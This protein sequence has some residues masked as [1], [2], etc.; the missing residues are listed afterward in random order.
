MEVPG[1]LEKSPGP[2]VSA[3]GDLRVAGA[4]RDGVVA[5]AAGSITVE[6]LIEC[7]Q[8]TSGAGLHARGGVNGKEKARLVAG[9]EFT[10][11]FVSSALV[12][13]GGQ[14]TIQAQFS[15]RLLCCGRLN[16]E[17]GAIVAGQVTA[18][19]GVVCN[20]LGSPTG[21][22]LV[23]EAG[24]DNRLL[25]ISASVQRA[26]E[27]QRRH[28]E[29]LRQALNP[30]LAGQKVM[31]AQQKERVT[32]LLYQSEQAESLVERCAGKLKAARLAWTNHS[33]PEVIV[34]GVAHPGGI[35]RF[36]GVE[37]RL[38]EEIAGPIAFMPRRRNG[39][40]E[41]CVTDIASGK[42]RPLPTDS[43]QQPAMEFFMH[44]QATASKALEGAKA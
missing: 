11:R 36:L 17:S 18:L 4:V 19:G 38:V 40:W 23:V 6:G 26:L 39:N 42:S 7:A 8:L 16:I 1:D 22:S 30:L 25:D 15:G 33:R 24:I 41:I 28:A 2:P 5:L 31:S 13:V 14:A 34:R 43:L 35:I 29:S 21:V 9:G 12:E 10:A 20:T 27:G 3:P 37:T 44:S 32:E